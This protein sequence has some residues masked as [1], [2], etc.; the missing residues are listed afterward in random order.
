MLSYRLLRCMVPWLAPMD[1]WSLLLLYSSSHYACTLNCGLL[2]IAAAYHV[3]KG[4]D[5]VEI[6]FDESKLQKHLVNCF[7]SEQLIPF[8]LAPPNTTVRQA[9]QQ[10][11]LIDINCSCGRRTLLK[12]WWP[13]TAATSD[14][15]FH[16]WTWNMH[17]KATGYRL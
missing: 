7:E 1:C 12:K 5:L 6:T 8:P 14:S 9:K 3:A 15:T 13:V 4:D 11:V 10:N 16:V 2:C 17:H